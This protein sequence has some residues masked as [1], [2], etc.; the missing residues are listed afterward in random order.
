[1]TLLPRPGV[2]IVTAVVWALLVFVFEAYRIFGVLSSPPH[3]EEYVSNLE[4]QLMVS[5]FMV[6]TRWLPLL[7]G[8]LVLE[9]MIFLLIPSPRRR[10][11]SRRSEEY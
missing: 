2:L 4:F 1:V 11:R 8:A 9:L 5:L 7:G 3:P 6:A 10:A